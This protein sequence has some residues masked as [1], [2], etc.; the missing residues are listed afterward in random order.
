MNKAVRYIIVCMIIAFLAVF[1][2]VVM[3]SLIGL[4]I[5]VLI[6]VVIF[7][8]YARRYQN[9]ARTFNL[10]AQAVCHKDGAMLKV[11]SAFARSG[12]IRGPCYEY[13]RRLMAGED[14]IEAATLSRVPLQLT[15][16][17]AMRNKQPAKTTLGRRGVL[18]HERMPLSDS[19]LMPAYAHIVY[20]VITA[21]VTSAI[22]GFV[23]VFIVPTME[24]IMEE[25]G[26]A[27]PHLWLIAGNA[28]T[29][30]ILVGVIFFV[31]FLIPVV[32]TGTFFGIPLPRW[33]PGSPRAVEGR[34]STLAGLADAIDAEMTVDQAL[35]LGAQVSLKLS[36]R[37]SLL[38]AHTLIQQG[39]SPADALYKSGWLNSYERN[40][41]GGATAER[42]AEILRTISRQR[43]RDAQAN[44]RWLVEVICPFIVLCLGMAILLFVYGL[45]STLVRLIGGLA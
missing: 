11:A 38:H 16:V 18:D 3:P 10:A 41:V 39:R 1:F 17:I 6:L 42:G 45:F 40:W 44:I 33:M 29:R 2:S 43:V 19:V 30:V 27:T 37:R 21:L 23:T 22:L 5:A 26:L 9:A 32:T 25:F 15:T 14:P 12:P 7:D 35:A 24:Q 34:A 13:T 8:F 20:L 4:L 36:D 31:L 28:P